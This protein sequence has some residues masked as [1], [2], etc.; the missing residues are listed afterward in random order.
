MSQ[1]VGAVLAT[2]RWFRDH[3]ITFAVVGGGL[4]LMFGCLYRYLFQP[5]WTAAQAL[6]VLWPLYLAGALSLLI[7]WLA[8]REAG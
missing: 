2:S 8:E 3:L 5:G 4:M 1:I 7:G 6:E